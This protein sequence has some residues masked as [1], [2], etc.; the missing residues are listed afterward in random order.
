MAAKPTRKPDT[1]PPA[2]IQTV[3]RNDKISTHTIQIIIHQTAD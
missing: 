1:P 2:Y 3:R